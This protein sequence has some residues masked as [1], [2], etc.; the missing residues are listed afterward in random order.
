MGP[1]SSKFRIAAATDL[2]SHALLVPWGLFAQEIG[3]IKG[4]ETIPIPQR[5]RDHAPQA[6]VLELYVGIL[7]GFAYLQDI[8]R[9]PHPLDQDQAVAQAW[10]Q[11]GWADYSGISRTLKVCT[12][13][14]VEALEAVLADV[15]R[16]FIDREVMLA[17]R[18][19]QVLVYDGDLTGHPVSSTSTSYP[20]TAF[21]WMSDEVRL[22]YQAALVS[23]HSP[24]YG[25]LWLSVK[26]HPGNTVA[27]S[28]AE[29]MVRAAE[30]ST[31]VRPRRRMELLAERITAQQALVQTTMEKQAAC[32]ARVVQARERLACVQQELE[33]WGRRVADL[34]ARYEA[35]E[36]PTGPHS[37]LSQARAKLRVQEQRLLRR[38]QALAKAQRGLERYRQRVADLQAELDALQRRLAQFQEDN[39]SN[40]APIRAIFRL[41]AGFGSGANIALLIEMGYDIYTKANNAQVVAAMRRKVDEKT[42]WTR[43]GK[44]AEM[45]T[46]EQVSITNCPYLLNVGLERFHARDK[47]KHAVL[48]HYGTDRVTADPIAWFN[49]Y[50][51]RQTIEAG[52]KESKNVFQMHH[53]KVRSQAGLA[54]QEQLTVFAANFVRWAAKWLNQNSTTTSEPLQRIQASVKQSVRIAANTTAQVTW[55]SQG[56]LLRF[57]ELSSLAGTV[58][59]VR[60]GGAFQLALP[61]FRSCISAPT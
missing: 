19:R 50:N 45:A 58:L 57:T 2:T 17:L 1:V 51:G 39:G 43:V 30:R 31:G 54:I 29:A 16:P 33:Q 48:L 12:A 55:Q 22:G 18:D 36:R 10:A 26:Q 52:I 21:G 13:G 27:G 56:C 61:L 5:T 53:L 4:I 11:Q 41:D 35:E 14:T 40:N 47:L 9:G 8:S 3:L 20:G 7:G 34:A 32:E 59:A 38:Q 24:T 6:K 28:Q 15:S 37:Q 44:N 23:M 25:R 60:T 49:F 46:W 42:T